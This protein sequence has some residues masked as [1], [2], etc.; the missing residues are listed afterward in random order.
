MDQ[1]RFTDI[2]VGPGSIDSGLSIGAAHALYYNIL[3]TAPFEGNQG[4]AE[5][6]AFLGREFGDDA[7]DAALSRHGDRIRVKRLPDPAA[8]AAALLADD[9]VIG[10]FEGR[11]EL[12]P[13]ALGHRSILA[14]PM[15]AANWQRVNSIKGREAWRPFAPAVLEEKAGEWFKGGPAVSPF[16]L[17]TAQ[18]ACDRLPAIT[19]RDGSAR[20]QTVSPRV[21]RLYDLLCYFEQLSG[22]PVVLNTSFNGPGEPIVETPEDALGFFIGSDLNALFLED[23]MVLQASSGLQFPEPPSPSP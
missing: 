14:N 17:F 9:H 10:W 18:V 2:F 20:I 11:S 4:T 21:G 7:I 5:S 6:C 12:G 1:G 16:M 23:R 8:A 13:R 22:V 19:H 3:E 15:H